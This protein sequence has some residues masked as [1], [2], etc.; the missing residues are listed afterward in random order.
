MLFHVLGTF[1]ILVIPFTLA[2]KYLTLAPSY[3]FWVGFFFLRLQISISKSDISC[4]M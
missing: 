1:L 4:T 3:A 2:L